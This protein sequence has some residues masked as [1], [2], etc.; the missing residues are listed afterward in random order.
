MHSRYISNTKIP[1]IDLKPVINKFIL[2]KWEKYWDDQTRN[3]LCHI[4]DTIG[5]WPTAY[6]IK[7]RN[8]NLQTSYWSHPHCRF[9]H[10][11]KRPSVCSTFKVLLTVKHILI[12]CD[13]FRQIRPKHYQTNNLKDLFKISKPEELFSFLKEAKLFI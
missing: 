11:R 5:K 4:Q 8:D 9:T 3:K 7:K 12:N 13:R 6:I 2:Q 10:K 1:H